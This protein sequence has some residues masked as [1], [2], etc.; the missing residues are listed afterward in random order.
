MEKCIKR[1]LCYFKLNWSKTGPFY[2]TLCF[3]KRT[4]N[5]GSRIFVINP[6][7]NFYKFLL[8]GSP[9]YVYLC[10]IIYNVLFTNILLKKGVKFPKILKIKNK[11]HSN[12]RYF[13]VIK[14]FWLPKC[15]DVFYCTKT[16][17]YFIISSIKKYKNSQICRKF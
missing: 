7:F 17:L 6:L 14:I 12:D 1:K 13:F 5:L 4:N 10:D 3:N 8:S 16:K 15:M 2:P 11:R 9:K